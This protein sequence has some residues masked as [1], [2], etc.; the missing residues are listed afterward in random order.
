MKLYS[1]QHTILMVGYTRWQSTGRYHNLCP[2]DLADSK[3]LLPVGNID[4]V[5][6]E[7]KKQR[8][9]NKLQV[10]ASPELEGCFSA[11]LQC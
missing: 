8:S 4:M 7:C 5:A 1:I 6:L 3:I 10:E 2:A 11:L 9:G